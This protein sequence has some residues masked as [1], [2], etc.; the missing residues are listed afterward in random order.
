MIRLANPARTPRQGVVQSCFGS[1]AR[2]KANNA[3]DANCGGGELVAVLQYKGLGF[4]GES[5]SL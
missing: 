5:A 3:L 1:G 2:A 4:D